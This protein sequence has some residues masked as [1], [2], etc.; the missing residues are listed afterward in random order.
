M[1]G[2]ERSVYIGRDANGAVIATGDGNFIFPGVTELSVEIIAAIKS[3][4]LK[5]GEV[6]GAVPL[7]ALVLR[8]AFVDGG[9][10][11]WEVTARPPGPDVTPVS[12]RMAVPW[13]N[14]RGGPFP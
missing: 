13:R 4:T 8:I 9:R 6:E 3:G 2:G 12:R 7:P 1:T 5:P 11:E 10:D 14:T